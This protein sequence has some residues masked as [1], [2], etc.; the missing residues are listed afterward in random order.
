LSLA[1]LTFI[2]HRLEVLRNLRYDNCIAA[3]VSDVYITQM[4]SKR[5]YVFVW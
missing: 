5:P 1:E 2:K 4:T 3:M